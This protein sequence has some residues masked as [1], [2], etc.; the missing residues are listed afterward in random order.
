MSFESDFERADWIDWLLMGRLFHRQVQLDKK[1][2]L[3]QEGPNL[4]QTM[5]QE[6]K[7]LKKV[8]TSWYDE[9]H[10]GVRMH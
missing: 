1:I 7:C 2:Y 4:R 10:M 6:R 9:E 8:T 3:C 5:E